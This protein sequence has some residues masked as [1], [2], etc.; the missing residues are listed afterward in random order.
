M[1]RFV[2]YASIPAFVQETGNLYTLEHLRMSSS[3]YRNICAIRHNQDQILI[4]FV[5][6]LGKYVVMPTCKNVAMN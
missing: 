1:V 3:I 6:R 2:R 4:K 5:C